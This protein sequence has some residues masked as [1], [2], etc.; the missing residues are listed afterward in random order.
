M[1]RLPGLGQAPERS[2]SA[3]PRIVL[4]LF[5]LA[6]VA[7]AALR[8]AE[9]QPLAVA[10]ALEAPPPVNALRVASLGEPQVLSQWMTLYLQAFDNQPGVS[11]PFASLDYA[12]VLAWL[13]SALAL[14]SAAHY[15]LMM[16]SHLYGQVNDPVRQRSMCEFVHREFIER[17]NRRWRWLAHCAIMARH[18]LKD[19]P[20]SLRYAEDIAMRAG[21]ASGWARQMRIFLL[22]D[23]GE[24]ERA[25]VLLGGLLAGNE[26]SDARERHFLT[27]QLEKLKKLA[28]DKASKN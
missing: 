5:V 3:V 7:H 14:D 17:P 11:V 21:A 1:W 4:V 2:I 19:M 23:M 25:T 22:E 8:F 6:L 26:V 20:L 16:A 10:A 27:G 24:V 15:P 18:R 9:P 28:K 12:Q 13:Q